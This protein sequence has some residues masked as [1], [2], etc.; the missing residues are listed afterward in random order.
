FIWNTAGAALGG[1]TLVAT[2]SYPDGNAANNQTSATVTVSV[3]STDVSVTNVTAPASVG[4]GGTVGINVSVQNVGTQHITASFNV[5]LTDQ[6]AG[7]SVSG[8]QGLRSLAAGASAARSFS[9]NTGTAALGAHTLVATQPLSDDNPSNT[10][11]S[12][13]VPVT[14]TPADIALASISA[15][16][17]VTVGDTAAVVVTVQNVGGE[18]VASSFDVVLTD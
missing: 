15:P 4:K 10:Q 16:G 14:P 9:W 11:R 8:T 2:H 5:V 7:G 13:P 3:P 1:H 17:Q 12:V 18:D 6:T